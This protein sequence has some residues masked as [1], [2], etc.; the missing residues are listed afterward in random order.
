MRASPKA[1]SSAA[2]TSGVVDYTILYRRQLDNGALAAESQTWSLFISA[3]NDSERVRSVFDVVACEK[4]WL[5]H[6]EY[7][8]AESERPS[9]SVFAPSSFNEAEFWAQ[10]IAEAAPDLTGDG[11]C[12]DLTG[13]MRPHLMFLVR[14][15]F[16]NGVQRFSALYTDPERYG[17]QEN[18][19]FTKGPVLAVRQVAGFEGVHA[20]DTSKDL[21][22]IGPGYDN[23]LIRRVADEKANARKLEIFGLPSLQAEMYQ[24]NVL[25][26]ALAAESVGSTT[27]TDVYFAPANDPFETAHVLQQIVARESARRG[28]TN[29]YLSSLATKPQALGFALYFLTEQS[30][31]AASMLFP[32]AERYTRES[33]VGVKRTWLYRVEQLA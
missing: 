29:L 19:Q 14:L 32:Y 25:N 33:S 28:I 10:Y 27:R 6:P 15:L 9:G 18:T 22:V 8:Y 1:P 17:E 3:Y 30:N 13:F 12:I 20:P 5:L 16:Q 7:Q 4:H 11:I 23:E 21:L 24:E 2:R 26:A 31:T